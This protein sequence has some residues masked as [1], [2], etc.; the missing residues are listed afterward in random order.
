MLKHGLVRR[1][2]KI[3][4]LLS[5][6]EIKSKSHYYPDFYTIEVCENFHLHWRNIRLNLLKDEWETLN[7]SLPI[8]YKRWS[9]LGK[10]YPHPNTLYL[11]NAWSELTHACFDPTRMAIELQDT[12][13]NKLPEI[14]WHYRS[15]RVDMSRKEL[16]EMISLFKE[17]EI[18]LNKWEAKENG[19]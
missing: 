2:G 7:A 5:E 16:R 18:E 1:L 6:R 13:V 4:K 3:L 12:G 14:H 19:R 8:A 17:A 15:L 11:H 10:P 9:L